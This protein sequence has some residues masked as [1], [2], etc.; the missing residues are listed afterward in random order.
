MKRY[1]PS[2]FLSFLFVLLVGCGF[3]LR[4]AVDLPD[5]LQRVYLQG[6]DIYRGVGRELKLNL[7]S[8]GVDVVNEYQEKTAVLTILENKI[9]R[10][11]LSV[12]GDAKVSEYELFG[13]LSFG[14]T[15]ADG[16]TLIERH[17]VQ[18]IRDYQ[19]N[20]DQVLGMDE[21]ESV[22]REQIY[23]Q[24]AQSILQRLSVLK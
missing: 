4:G 11:V 24:L 7:V 16:E 19:F 6:V 22:L 10:R 3:H 2:L 21:E 15:D 20:Q 23:Q 9:E 1:L 5:S 8:N 13:T 18:A 12:G 14:L 17:E